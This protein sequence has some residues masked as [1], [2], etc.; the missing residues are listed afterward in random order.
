MHIEI[1][2]NTSMREIQEVFSE[3]YPYLK[4]EFYRK[5]NKKYEASE[6]TD[7]IDVDPSTT[8]GDVKQTHVSGV[9]EIR[10]LYKDA[11]VEKEFQ[12]RFGLSVQIFRKEKDSWEQTTGMDNFTLKELN[13]M[14]RN[15]SDEFIVSDYEE[16]FEENGDKPEKLF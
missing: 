2:D 11:D 12:Q 6:E 9:L 16:G 3:F 15:S 13:E 7:L 14:G 10:P 8:I 4:I 1:N 5:K